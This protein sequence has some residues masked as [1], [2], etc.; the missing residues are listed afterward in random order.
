MDHNYFDSTLRAYVDKTAGFRKSEPLLGEAS[1]ETAF[2][3]LEEALVL[4]YDSKGLQHPAGLRAHSTYGVAVSWAL[5]QGVSIEEICAA[6]SWVTPH[7]FS[8]FY[9]LDVTVSQ[10]CR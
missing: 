8:R 7:T 5:F 10:F 1:Y 4:Y 9:K 3:M 6:A 2:V